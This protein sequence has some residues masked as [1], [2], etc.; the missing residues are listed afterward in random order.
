MRLCVVTFSI[1]SITIHACGLLCS[2]RAAWNALECKA[3]PAYILVKPSNAGMRYHEHLYKH[4]KERNVKL[5]TFLLG[6]AF[7][8][9]IPIIAGMMCCGN[10]ASS[11]V[12]LKPPLSKV[13]EDEAETVWKEEV[14]EK[15]PSLATVKYCGD[16]VHELLSK[17]YG[18]FI[19]T[20]SKRVD[21]VDEMKVWRGVGHYLSPVNGLYD[22]TNS[23]R[24]TVKD[25][26]VIEA[27]RLWSKVPEVR[28]S[29][30]VVFFA[31]LFFLCCA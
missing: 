23:F 19:R 25:Y 28:R 13:V 31:F 9:A 14:L 4:H 16:N 18:N 2:E 6:R 30:V 8:R 12:Q 26:F 5:S 17:H 1:L 11:A 24:R 21:T 27:F 20:V 10:G 15:D 29:Y 22:Y 7:Q 3:S